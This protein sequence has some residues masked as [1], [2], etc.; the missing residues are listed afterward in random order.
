MFAAS[1]LL[2]WLVGVFVPLPGTAYAL[3]FSFLA[4]AIVAVTMT[5]ELRDITSNTRFGFFF[6]GTG[7]FSGA[8]L[9][10]EHFAGLD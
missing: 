4:G 6:I 9:L 1:A 5:C 8:L 3:W 10:L 7:V 2:G